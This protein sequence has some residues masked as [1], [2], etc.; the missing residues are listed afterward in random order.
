MKRIPF[1][2]LFSI[3]LGVASVT[4]LSAQAPAK[5]PIAVLDLDPKGVEKSMAGVITDRVRYEFGRRK[6]AFDLVARE[7]MFELTKEKAFQL[8]GCTDVSCAVQIGKAL[9]VKKMV[10]GSV[11]KLGH[12]YQIFLQ[13]VDV[14]KENVECSELREAELREEEV[15]SLVPT[16]VR[17]MAACLLAQGKDSTGAVSRREP[18]METGTLKFGSTPG[19][20]RVF[21]DGIYWGLTPRLVSPLETGDHQVALLAEG[22]KEYTGRVTVRGGDT[23]ALDVR[24]EKILGSLRVFSK[25]SGVTVFLDGQKK[26]ATK[27]SGLLIDN[28]AIKS[29]QMKLARS[30][31]YKSRVEQV[32]TIPSQEKEVRSSLALKRASLNFGGGAWIPNHFEDSRFPGAVIKSGHY[33]IRDYSPGMYGGTGGSGKPGFSFYLMWGRYL[34]E[35]FRLSLQADWCRSEFYKAGG[36]SLPLRYYFRDVTLLPW[37]AGLA[38]TVPLGY[39]EPYAEGRFGYGFV[40]SN[41][42]VDT[43][44]N[45]NAYTGSQSSNGSIL[46]YRLGGGLKFRL[47]GTMTL[48]L[49]TYYDHS[50]INEKDY[51]V[52]ISSVNSDVGFGFIF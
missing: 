10:I 45:P 17:K 37:T 33:D 43:S 51:T 34:N 4:P 27:S 52:K 44:S 6:D 19:G 26:G 5:L 11:G 48:D 31:R 35:W 2:S 13:V 23:T 24:L 39:F 50:K 18:T 41:V 3:S 9:N 12:N 15:S 8:T 49:R 22:Y 36:D 14:E 40:I 16:A 29:Y 42:S 20:V 1:L 47:G 7:K 46:T 30:P 28:L 21:V 32:E 25:P 38:T